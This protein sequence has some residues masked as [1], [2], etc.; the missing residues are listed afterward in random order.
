MSDFSPNLGLG[1]LGKTLKGDTMKNKILLAFAALTFVI[2]CSKAPKEYDK[3]TVNDND[4]PHE[5]QSEQEMFE[6][7]FSKAEKLS[8]A[9]GEISTEDLLNFDPSSMQPGGEEFDKK[10]KFNSSQP[11]IY[12]S[13]KNGGAA[14]I[15]F[16]MTYEE[17]QA[18]AIPRT[19]PN[20]NGDAQYDENMVIR[21]RRQDP[22]TPAYFQIYGGYTGEVQVP[23][24]YAPFKLK[25]E[26]NKQYP[27][28]EEGAMQ[29]TR[30]FYNMFEGKDQSFDCLKVGYCSV[31]WGPAAQKNFLV[32]LPGM[33]IGL[34]KDRF[35]VYVFIVVKNTP[36]GP[37]DANLD[38]VTGKFMINGDMF[39]DLQGETISIGDTFESVEKKLNIETET[40]AGTDSF[41]RNYSGIFLGYHRTQFDRDDLLP[42]PTDTLKMV[43]VYRDYKQNLLINGLP[44]VVREYTDNVELELAKSADFIPQD[45]GTHR[46]VPLA[47][48][49]G[50]KRQNVRI[51][52]EKMKT[53]LALEM[54]KAFPKASIT[55]HMT[56]AFQNKEIKSYDIF[57]I[58]YD[59]LS[60]QGKFISLAI[61]EEDGNLSSFTIVNL[62]E[63]YNQFDPL[64]MQEVMTPVQKVMVTQQVISEF[65][66]PVVDEKGQ[67][68]MQ[69]IKSPFFTEISG[70][71]VGQMVKVENWD[72]GRGQAD[73]SYERNGQVVKA[74]A[75]YLDRGVQNVAFDVSEKVKPQKQAFVDLGSMTV[76][77]G[78]SAEPVSETETER[79]YSIVSISTAM[80]LN[81]VRDL[82]GG[83]NIN[84]KIGTPVADFV[85]ILQKTTCPYKI[86]RDTGGNGRIES[87]YFPED[88]IRLNFAGLELTGVTVYSPAVGGK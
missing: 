29:I 18:V 4:R 84:V 54:A 3:E 59:G 85:D 2:G 62:G 86:V 32:I 10:V 12:A 37:L 51:F 42:L 50:L 63:N 1:A 26:F 56:G 57:V 76:S 44:V 78:L 68:K 24:P 25:H 43:Q 46:E 53:F 30:E 58:V 74:R 81:E 83:L 87:I 70:F 7:L 80:K 15:P 5:Q 11:I 27:T 8:S 22:R 21:W 45:F 9:D 66:N 40:N 6:S 64:I 14:G 28:T 20:V 77:L 55:P 17:S 35:R 16:T 48:S 23:S 82:C 33:I 38:I 47:I 79:M 49:L 19:P 52:A 13:G 34:S 36:Q 67:P 41:G 73:V 65:G 72:L 39:P 61:D 31:N 69:T 71:A 88:R 60:K 75:D